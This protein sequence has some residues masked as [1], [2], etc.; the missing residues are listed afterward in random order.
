MELP[1]D[2]DCAYAVATRGR[3]M[4]TVCD[5][6]GVAR[7]GV[8]VRRIRPYDWRDGFHGDRVERQHQF[9]R[10]DRRQRPLIILTGS[11]VGEA[12]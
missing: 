1:K 10:L 2:T 7:S 9:P 6:L 5:A 11:F 4:K 8:A 3:P 12:R